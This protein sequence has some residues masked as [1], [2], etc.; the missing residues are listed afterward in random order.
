[1]KIFIYSK[2]RHVGSETVTGAANS[3]VNA[4]ISEETKCRTSKEKSIA[5]VTVG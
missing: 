3:N 2:I 1:M 4:H 5:G